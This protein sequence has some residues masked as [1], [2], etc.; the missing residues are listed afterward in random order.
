MELLIGWP[1]QAAVR[2]QVMTRKGEGLPRVFSRY[3]TMCVRISKFGL[4]TPKRKQ[5]LTRGCDPPLQEPIRGAWVQTV[6][7]NLGTAG[8]KWETF[9]WLEE[10]RLKS[11]S[12]LQS[13]TAG[14]RATSCFLLSASCRDHCHKPSSCGHPLFLKPR[15]T[16]HADDHFLVWTRPLA[17]FK[18]KAPEDVAQVDQSES[19]SDS[20][21]GWD[22]ADIS[23]IVRLWAWPARV[24]FLVW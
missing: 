24:R 9:F 4:E 17:P 2:P 8:R 16:V 11:L 21:D 1:A 12:S 19:T 5:L 23:F 18:I 15:R 13:G 20:W 10:K 22:C 6:P 7:L 14:S 3:S